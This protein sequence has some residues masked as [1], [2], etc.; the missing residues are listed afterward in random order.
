MHFR[1]D[2]AAHLMNTDTNSED[3]RDD[4]LQNAR[5]MS[6]LMVAYK[7]ASS[8]K[9]SKREQLGDD[10]RQWIHNDLN[11]NKPD[12]LDLTRTYSIEL[13]YDWSTFR[14]TTLILVPLITSL[15][16]GTLY[17]H[18]KGDIVAAWTISLYIVTCIL[19]MSPFYLVGRMNN[20]NSLNSRGCSLNY[21][22]LFGRSIKYS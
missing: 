15:L 22:H 1:S 13:I 16:V 3:H 18:M 7:L 19:G 10:W 8:S 4:L 12:P 6:D 17:A 9:L 5:I 20:T 14:I 11:N 21:Y 2:S